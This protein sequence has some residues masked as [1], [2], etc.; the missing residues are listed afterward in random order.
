MWD[1]VEYLCDI[2]GGELSS[3]QDKEG[4]TAVAALSA[5]PET[6]SHIMDYIGGKKM[7]QSKE[8]NYDSDE[9]CM[10]DCDERT[11]ESDQSKEHNCDSDEGMSDSDRDGWSSCMKSG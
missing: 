11:S 5:D 1:I 2:A 6:P 8:H 7:D 10:P 9:T 3:L 4:L